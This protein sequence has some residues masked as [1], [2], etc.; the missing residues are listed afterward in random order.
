LAISKEKASQDPEKEKEFIILFF[1]LLSLH[2][3][4][5]YLFVIQEE[6]ERKKKKR[7]GNLRKG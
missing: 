3:I 7:T 5:F 4:P 2:F 1:C 6:R